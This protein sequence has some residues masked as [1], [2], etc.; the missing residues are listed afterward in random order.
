MFLY[1]CEDNLESI[2]TAIYRVY[3]ERRD[4]SDVRLALEDEAWLFSTVIPVVPD[5]ER[6]DKVIRTLRRRF[7]EKDY[8]S[9]CLALASPDPEKAQA[10]YGTVTAGLDGG[11]GWG[12]LFDNLA[13]DD[14]NR[15]FHLAVNARREN[16]HLRGFTRFSE[17]E[18]GILYGEIRP[19]ND[20]I[21]FLMAHFADR[22]A[23][24][25]FVLRDAGRGLFGVHPAGEEWY[26]LRGAHLMWEEPCFSASE[27]KYQNLFRQFCQSITI[28]ARRNAGL[29]QN[30]L[31]LRFRE[32]MT[33]F[34]AE[35]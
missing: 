19:K 18:N 9:V 1:R 33:E 7:G 3:E 27:E 25:N 4:R 20:L 13:N 5:P 2:F 15:A 14:V 32:F 35:G 6:C 30:M 17:L 23:G 16:D 22:F 28:D 8:E 11:C 31:P 29:Q 12:R 21:P 24:E 10:V 34:K 26:L